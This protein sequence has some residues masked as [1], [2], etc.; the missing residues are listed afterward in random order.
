MGAG[1]LPLTA[2]IA[3]CSQDGGAT[4][5]GSGPT[6]SRM[7]T[8]P[9]TTVPGTTLAPTTLAPTTLPGTTL[10][11]DPT[12]PWWL[13][14]NYAPVMD[15][16]DATDLVIRGALP[17]ELNGYYVKNSSN[18]PRSDSPH[19]FFGDGMVHGLQL[20]GGT[21]QSY[22]NR[23]VRTQPFTERTGFGKG[24]PGGQNS[25]S[26]VSVFS[27]GG[28]LLSSGE[29]GFPYELDIADLSTVGAWDYAGVLQGSFTAHPKVDPVTGRMHAFGY[30]FAAPFLEYYIIE[31][32]GTMSHRETIP[33]PH[34]TMIHDF[35]ITE[36]DAIFWDMPVVFD[37]E[38]AIQYIN[39]PTSGV[40]PYQWQ[41]EFGSRIGIMPL[42]G[43]ADQITWY[44]IDPC[45]VFHSI[46][47]FRNGDEVYIDV[48]RMT[49]MFDAT[50]NDGLGGELSLRRWTVN[51]ATGTV[52][53]DV[54]ATDNPGDL[55]SRDPR[56]VGREHRYGYLTGTR[57]NAHTVELGGV[58]K[59]DFTN[60]SRSTWEPGPTRHATE[61]LFVPGDA[62]DLADDAGWLL[63]FVHDDATDESV[64]AVL[65]ATDV[66]AGPVAEIVIPQ[67][68][69]YGFHGTWVDAGRS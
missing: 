46:N 18:P 4:P 44:D 21:A 63:S 55:P 43:G 22:R 17:P 57:E 31:P 52:T 35:Q 36:T 38:L 6:S 14:G 40:M 53:D 68:V 8:L 2:L 30:G 58:I 37:L 27:H 19:W 5:G 11:T 60:G 56:R 39:D 34:S 41:P 1:S 16:I 61:P 24:T 67:R 26:N 69:P 32:D 9:S 65:D 54:L 15:E 48:C 12:K 25:Q 50:V 47:A 29:V 51:T 45:Y 62:T 49:S 64:L 10:P 33:T 13:Q 3:A 66:A 7:T 20:G 28:K 23:W 42:A 59:H